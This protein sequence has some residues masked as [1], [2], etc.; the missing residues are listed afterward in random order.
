MSDSER[1]RYTYSLI[2]YVPDP[3][4]G[5]FV[6]IGVLLQEE[7]MPEHVELSFTKDWSRVRCVDRDAD[8]AML[9]AFGSDI[10]KILK[11]APDS[12]QRF[13]DSFSNGLQMTEPK[14]CL[15]ESPKAKLEQL[16]SMFVESI[17]VPKAQRLSG[18]GHLQSQMREAFKRESVLEYMK[19]RIAVSDYTEQKGNPL[20]IDFGYQP[21]GIIRMFQAVSL[22]GEIDAATSLS[23]SVSALEEGVRKVAQAGLE[24]TAIVE[25]VEQALNAESRDKY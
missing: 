17:K 23:F 24:L 8:V 1:L 9:Q 25:P 21:D 2:R 19:R 11:E 10:Q 14:G 4:R 7:H 5:E 20:M 13:R 3:I 15:A 16:M 12:L 22:L 6:N 18:R